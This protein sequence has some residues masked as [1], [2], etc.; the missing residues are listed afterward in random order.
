MQASTAASNS[1]TPLVAP[2]LA[3]AARVRSTGMRAQQRKW[4][5]MPLALL[6]TAG[7]ATRLP[8]PEE[9]IA[10]WLSEAPRT[11]SVYVDHKLPQPSV[12]SRDHKVGE[13]IGSGVDTRARN[14]AGAIGQL[15]LVAGPLGC[16]F[17][18]V[19]APF[20]IA[21]GA[22]VRAAKV[23]SV[24]QSHPIEAAQGAPALFELTGKTID[25]RALLAERVA[26]EARAE[27]V[28]VLQVARGDA[29]GD[30]PPKADGEL[31]L[32]LQ[33]VELFGGTG[34]DPH[35]A[36]IL[37]VRADMRTPDAESLGW[38]DFAYEGPARLVSEWSVD[39]ARLFREEFAVAVRKIATQIV[40]QLAPP[41][42]PQAVTR[43]AASRSV[44]S[45][46]LSGYT[47]CNFHYEDDWISDANWSA[48][49]M[50]PAG[51]LVRTLEFRSYRV[52][53]E[54]GGRRMGL[55]LDYG[56]DQKL[57]EWSR[58]MIVQEDPRPKIESWPAPVR[59]AVRDGK[60]AIGMTKE[61][62]IVSLGYPPAHETPSIDAQQW[63]Y[64]HTDAAP[65]QVLWDTSGRVKTI[66]A[67]RP[68]RAAVLIT[69]GSQPD[70]P[71]GGT[72]TLASAD[73]QAGTSPVKPTANADQPLESTLPR[74]G[75][76]WDYEYVQRG[77]SRQKL[78]YSARVDRI[79]GSS[80]QEII[81]VTGQP[82]VLVVSRAGQ[83]AFR[84]IALPR[85]D[86][87]IEFSPYLAT[88]SETDDGSPPLQ[89]SG[90][91]VGLQV[92]GYPT[93]SL[94]HLRW[95]YAVRYFGWEDVITPAGTFRALQ[96]Q[97]AGNRSGV[98]LGPLAY[99][100]TG[101]F[102]YRAWYSP[103]VR[104]YVKIQH[105]SWSVSGQAFGSETVELVKHSTR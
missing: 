7:C 70:A 60:V 74:P 20:A 17:G 98:P 95:E 58:R 84:V 47:C 18:V 42:P 63:T 76:T 79:E 59:D 8:T 3:S 82:D 48:L 72:A 83:T 19:A 88:T 55:G 81:A 62:V 52:V 25:V 5:L 61:Q 28:H 57:T 94:P 69:D 103:A 49:P 36:L 1:A 68:I 97:I 15:C 16:V 34:D 75:A 65:Y 56:R 53:V 67:A 71:Q 4:L 38:G 50:I 93:G 40:H 100:N 66:I 87:F 6:F 96:I 33:A 10:V 37:R 44:E 77:V 24:D 35:V 43:V 26:A 31:K 27:R 13:R 22:T 41:V 89:A 85:S 29:Q 78:G 21:I 104:R 105:E 91:P 92:S 101:R 51:S 90:Y 102:V 2:T 54:L 32:Y 9:Q 11:L 99:A 39:D 80:I 14:V 30:A 12:R 73:T 23:K 64:W 86:S 45:P 46:P